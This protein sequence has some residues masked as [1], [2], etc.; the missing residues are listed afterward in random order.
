MT[1][2]RNTVIITGRLTKTPTLYEHINFAVLTFD[3]AYNE[4]IYKHGEPVKETSFFKV[5]RKGEPET[6]KNLYNRLDKGI[7]VSVD[8]KLKQERWEK[9]GKNYDQVVIYAESVGI[10]KTQKTEDYLGD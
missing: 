6:I 10:H 7:K 2:E 4:I 5:K 1:N 8:G 9:E 3:L